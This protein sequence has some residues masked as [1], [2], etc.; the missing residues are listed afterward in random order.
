MR[1]W[2]AGVGLAQ[3]AYCIHRLPIYCVL[4]V[5][6]TLQHHSKNSDTSFLKLKHF[7]AYLKQV[8]CKIQQH[9]T[10]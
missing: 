8:F 6:R 2:R 4:H 7:V 5:Q 3:L 9:S 10:T 1:V